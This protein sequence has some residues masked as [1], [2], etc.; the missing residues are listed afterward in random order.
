METDENRQKTT[1][2]DREPTYDRQESDGL[3]LVPEEFREE[4]SHYRA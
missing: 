2:T 4:A 1:K 3:D